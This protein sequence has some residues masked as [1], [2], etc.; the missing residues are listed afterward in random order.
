MKR[1]RYKRTACLC[2][3]ALP[4]LFTISLLAQETVFNVPSGDVLNRGKVYFELDG[5]YMP[6][7]AVRSFTPRIVAG[8][9]DQI[10]IG[11]NVN[12]V[13]APANPQ[14]TLTPTIK[15]KAYDGQKKRMGVSDRR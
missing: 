2:V 11:F 4:L 8:V 13:S 3:G 12:G 6:G 9:G 5:T 14:T 7:T 10:E 1:D 15:W